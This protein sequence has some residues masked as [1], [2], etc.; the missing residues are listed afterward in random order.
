[1]Y[2]AARGDDEAALRGL[3]AGDGRAPRQEDLDK[4]SAEEGGRTLLM[5]AAAAGSVRVASLLLELGASINQRHRVSGKTAL[6]LAVEFAHEECAMALVKAG[7]ALHLGGGSRAF[8][9]LRR[10]MY[11]A[12]ARTGEPL[13]IARAGC[14]PLPGDHAQ[15]SR[16][17]ELLCAIPAGRLTSISSTWRRPQARRSRKTSRSPSSR[18]RCADSLRLWPSARP[19][20]PRRSVAR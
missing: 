12:S 15:V 8:P 19:R 18:V 20:A 10:A 6:A 3:L 2:A 9:I 16:L 4:G 13:A 5:E 17:S 14:V 7:A 1:M 11:G